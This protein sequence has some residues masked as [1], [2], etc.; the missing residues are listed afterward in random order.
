MT[1]P[2]YGLPQPAVA[3]G[4]QII[5]GHAVHRA[6]CSI[7]SRGSNSWKLRRGPA[8]KRC[9]RPEDVEHAAPLGA[10]RRT[11]LPKPVP[12]VSQ[13]RICTTIGTT[14]ELDK[15]DWEAKLPFVDCA[16]ITKWNNLEGTVADSLVNFGSLLFSRSFTRAYA[17][18]TQSRSLP[19][20]AG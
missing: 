6:P 19:A 17:L 1:T 5:D 14:I 18:S 11:R 12:D 8:G 15:T 2:L 7:S 16:R 13:L 9:C 3:Q 10:L 4:G 20:K